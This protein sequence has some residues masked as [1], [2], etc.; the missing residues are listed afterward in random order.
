[1][2]FKDLEDIFEEWVPP[3]REPTKEAYIL[4]ARDLYFPNDT[5]V[6]IH[7]DK[8]Y[9]EVI[10]GPS[11]KLPDGASSVLISGKAGSFAQEKLDAPNAFGLGIS[12]ISNDALYYIEMS[13]HLEY[14]GHSNL[15]QE[16]ASELGYL[17]GWVQRLML[18]AGKTDDP[19]YIELKKRDGP[20]S[21]WNDIAKSM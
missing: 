11:A 3:A 13:Q 14:P 15:E 6:I 10:A 19:L 17:R 9:A 4:A 5:K 20:N 7:E 21:V 18:S 8:D 2:D 16:L 1:M 12:N